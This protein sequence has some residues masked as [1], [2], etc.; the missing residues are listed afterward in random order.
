MDD[1]S[2]QGVFIHKRLM[3]KIA[4]GKSKVTKIHVNN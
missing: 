3:N 4:K 1:K 2:L